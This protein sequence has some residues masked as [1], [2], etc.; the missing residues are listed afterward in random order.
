MRGSTLN[1][2][3]AFRAAL[4][5]LALAGCGTDE[6]TAPPPTAA[7]CI[8]GLSA[9]ATCYGGTQLSGASYQI[10]V[11]TNWNGILVVVARGATPVPATELRTFGGARSLLR[12]GGLALAATTYRS[13][14]PLARD[15]TDDVEE[16]RRIFVAKFG[17]PKRT[18]IWRLS[19]GGLVAAR[20]AERFG[21]FDGVVSLC[22]LM[23]GTLRSLY[24]QLD[25]RTVYQ[26][27]CRNLPRS[28]EPRYDLFLGLAPQATLTA[29]E[30]QARVNECT[31]ISLPAAQ[32]SAA[33]RENLANILAVLRIPES[34][35]LTNM[36]A[37]TALL[38]T[39]VQETL[40]GHNP[41]Q[42]TNVRYTGSTDDIALNRDVPRYPAE[43]QAATALASADDPTG[44]PR[45]PV[46][47]LHAIDDPRAFVENQSAYRAAV[48][49]S[50]A[51]G[52][53]FQAFTNQGGHCQFTTAEQ[54][55]ALQV[56]LDWI[57]TRTPPTNE[58]LAAACEKYRL[59]FGTSCR[60]NAGYQPAALE[61]RLY[62]RQP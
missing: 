38:K 40:G 24:T 37:A 16:L 4:G 7:T 47:T 46:L 12:D 62:P 57:E 31:G 13:D 25:A 28:D 3:R 30:L 2:S 55:G 44:R 19:F 48:T 5:T 26:Y 27:Y 39:F 14:T 41:L 21:T 10:A 53:L 50:G 23:A 54:L 29:T 59:E 60:F 56:V 9:Q 58:A 22:G 45:V 52:N 61:T 11:P 51:L 17:R 8:T 36:D 20:C 33:Q 43:N 32:R 34:G 15:A 49:K 6:A 35:L 42:N 18:I 1:R